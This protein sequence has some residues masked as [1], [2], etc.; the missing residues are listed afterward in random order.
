MSATFP[1]VCPPAPDPYCRPLTPSI[2]PAPPTYD[3][4]IARFHLDFSITG[5]ND[6]YYKDKENIL[7]LYPNPTQGYVTISIAME[8]K[9]DVNVKLYNSLGQIL[10]EDVLREQT[11]RIKHE[12]DLRD[13]EKGF[14]MLQVMIGSEKVNKKVIKH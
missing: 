11:G 5:I 9:D 1:E 4:F 10:K 13:L 3:V 6:D 8:Q 2:P 12:L 14:Y 7:L